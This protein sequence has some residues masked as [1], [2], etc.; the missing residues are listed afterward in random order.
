MLSTPCRRAQRKR[1]RFG[2]TRHIPHACARDPGRHYRSARRFDLK[3]GTTHNI[4]LLPLAV[5]RRADNPIYVTWTGSNTIPGDAVNS[6]RYTPS[7]ETHVTEVVRDPIDQSQIFGVAVR[8]LRPIPI[9]SFWRRPSLSL[10]VLSALH[11]SCSTVT[12]FP[13][14]SVAL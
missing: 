13:G 8:D 9:T 12:S 10:A 14:L 1:H 2:R 4:Q 6:P 5:R 11:R 7:P 3:D